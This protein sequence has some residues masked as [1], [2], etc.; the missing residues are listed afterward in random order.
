MVDFQKRR[1]K[2]A[3][4]TR[5][6]VGG[7]G[8]LAL[9]LVAFFAGRSAL[10]MYGKFAEASAAQAGAEDRLA[11]LQGRYTSVKTQVDAL[12]SERGVEA[13]IRE[14]WGLAKPGEGE[15]DIV[16]ESSTT[17]ATTPAP[18]I[19]ERLWQILFVW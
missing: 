18:N 15:L 7:A 4:L 3:Q 1:S 16:R 19:L 13:A 14:R 10:D 12:D 17:P 11:E 6:I 5:A 8:M 2:G 9:A